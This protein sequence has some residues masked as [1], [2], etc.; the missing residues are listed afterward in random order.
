MKFK[1]R[2]REIEAE[3]F[4]KD[5]PLPFLTRGPVVCFDGNNWY[6]ETIHH[7]KI[8][9][10]Y[11]DWVILEGEGFYAYPCR[12]HIFETNYEIAPLCS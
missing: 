2:V 7:D 12:P 5:Q 10:L 3:Q 1:T 6:V 8:P 4:L 11:G 9:L